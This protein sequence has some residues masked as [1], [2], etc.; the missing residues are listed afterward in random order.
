V[1][2]RY[3]AAVGQRDFQTARQHLAERGFHYS[4]PIA[5]FDDA[6]RFAASMDIAGAILQRMEV[7]HRFTDGDVVCHILDVTVALNGYK[8]L[9]VAHLARVKSGKI[10]RMEV[11]FD[12]SDHRLMIGE[13]SEPDDGGND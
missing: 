11:I 6:D 1:V 5:H 13:P 8:T 12:G 2:E 9:S 3:L 10:A 7:R 4:S